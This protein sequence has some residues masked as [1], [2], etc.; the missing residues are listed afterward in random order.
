MTRRSDHATTARPAGP[1]RAQGRGT[2][3]MC[4]SNRACGQSCRPQQLQDRRS[5]GATAARKE[6]G[7][8]HQLGA[9]VAPAQ[10]GTWHS[11]RRAGPLS[12]AGGSACRAHPANSEPEPRRCRP[13][14]WNQS[15]AKGR[16]RLADNPRS[17]RILAVEQPVNVAICRGAQRTPTRRPR[18]QGPPVS[19]C[20]LR[21]LCNQNTGNQEG[22][23]RWLST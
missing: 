9:R 8:L 14:Q 23:R 13:G 22:S 5:G 7:A 10:G 20:Y 17:G 6:A 1:T 12:C 4:F 16:V 19:C 11:Q 21:L 15:M 2:A 18:G 3:T